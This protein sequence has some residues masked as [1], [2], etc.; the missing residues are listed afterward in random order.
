MALDQ[1]DVELIE[2]IIYKNADDIA[3][4]VARSFERIEERLDAVESHIHARIA[5][6][7]DKIESARQDIEDNI[8]SLRDARKG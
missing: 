1:K 4:S 8:E 3:A 5:D 2:R 6:A 7:E